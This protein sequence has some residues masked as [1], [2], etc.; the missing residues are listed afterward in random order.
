MQAIASLNF[1]IINIYG[2]IGYGSGESTLKMLGD[3][4]L[5]YG[6]RSRTISDPINS[7]FNASGMRT[8]LG[9]RLSLGFF[10]IFGS[11]TLQEYNTANLGIAFSFR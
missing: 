4:T 5:R 3:Y 7:K 2:G 1:P 8:T 11:Y 6:I 9:T 10:K